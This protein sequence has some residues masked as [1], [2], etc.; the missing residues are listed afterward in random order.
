MHSRITT[1]DFPTQNKK[2]QDMCLRIQSFHSQKCTLDK[3]ALP[4][5]SAV[6]SEKSEQTP[7]G[8]G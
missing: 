5:S 2:K 3:E 7:E 8:Y 4:C 1:C 6:Q